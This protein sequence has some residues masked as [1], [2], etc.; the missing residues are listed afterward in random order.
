MRFVILDCGNVFGLE[1]KNGVDVLLTNRFS[2]TFLRFDCTEAGDGCSDHIL[3]AIVIV[4]LNELD[5]PVAQFDFEI[6]NAEMK[7]NREIRA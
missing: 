7:A 3:N 5:S 4:W 6:K 2:N 1:Q